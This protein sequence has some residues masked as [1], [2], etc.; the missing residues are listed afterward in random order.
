MGYMLSIINP[1]QYAARFKI[2]EVFVCTRLTIANKATFS[3][4]HTWQVAQTTPTLAS[5]IWSSGSFH[6][7]I[8]FLRPIQQSYFRDMEEWPMH[9]K[10]LKPALFTSLWETKTPKQIWSSRQQTRHGRWERIPLT[11]YTPKGLQPVRWSQCVLWSWAPISS[12]LQ[13]LLQPSLPN[14]S[15][16]SSEHLVWGRVSHDKVSLSL[17]SFLLY[18]K[19]AWVAGLWR[20]LPVGDWHW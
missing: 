6:F 5:R 7:P 18:S 12:S 16:Q 14:T 3:W 15:N 11:S 13:S 1:Q 10:N 8:I 20:D 19:V 9:W 4:W 2:F 17:I